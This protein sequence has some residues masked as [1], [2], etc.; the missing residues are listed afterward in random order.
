M[1]TTQATIET[2]IST[3]APTP[4]ENRSKRETP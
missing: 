1:G 2:T 3:T 4:N